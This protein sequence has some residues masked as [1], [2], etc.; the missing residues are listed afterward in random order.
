MSKQNQ[1]EI[2]TNG[3]RKLIF[4]DGMMLHSVLDIDVPL[5]QGEIAPR[6]TIKLHPELVTIRQVDGKWITDMLKPSPLTADDEAQLFG[7]AYQ[8]MVNA[9]ASHADRQQQRELLPRILE[10]LKALRSLMEGV[11][12]GGNSVSVNVE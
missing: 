9:F 12:Q 8:A 10:E 3:C 2:L 7:A 5:E 11:T 1:V 4:I 6:V